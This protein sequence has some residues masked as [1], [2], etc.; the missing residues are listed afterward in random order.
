MRSYRFQGHGHNDREGV[1]H[2]IAANGHHEKHGEDEG[3]GSQDEGEELLI[4]T[5]R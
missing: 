2:E 5:Q 3:A 4:S 1:I